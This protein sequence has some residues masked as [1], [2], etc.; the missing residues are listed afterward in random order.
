M[1]QS[2]MF[3][4]GC[5]A[6]AIIYGAVSIRW[7]VALPTGNK[8]MQEIAPDTLSPLEALSLLYEL[9]KL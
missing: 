6:L 3:A 9:K 5:A 4:L 7:I 1:S 8:K 2:L